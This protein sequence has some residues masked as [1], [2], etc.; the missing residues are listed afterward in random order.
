MKI[1]NWNAEKNELLIVDRG[2]SFEESK[3]GFD[4][5][6]ALELMESGEKRASGKVRQLVQVQLEDI[7]TVLD[8]RQEEKVVFDETREAVVGVRQI[9]QGD[10]VL[11]ANFLRSFQRVCGHLTGGCD[12][13]GAD[14]KS[15]QHRPR[16][17]R[18]R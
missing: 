5:F 13:C 9:C 3:R 11:L 17:A 16:N 1:Y 15:C 12:R 18:H 2:V 8:V 14:A 4:F 7:K 6:I 10:L